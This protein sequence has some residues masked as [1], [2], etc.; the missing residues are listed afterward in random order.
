LIVADYKTTTVG[1]KSLKLVAARY[2][3][4][5]AAYQDAVKKTLKRKAKFEV[6]FLKEGKSVFLPT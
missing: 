2:K 1:K 4:Q 5:G 3:A 6:I